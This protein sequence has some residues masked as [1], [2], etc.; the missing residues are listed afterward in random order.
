MKYFGKFD[1]KTAELSKEEI[2]KLLYS[3]GLLIEMVVADEKEIKGKTLFFDITGSDVEPIKDLS[4][5]FC[6]FIID[7]YETPILE[8][9]LPFFK[10]FND[11]IYGLDYKEQKTIGLKY[12]KEIYDTIYIDLI[13]FFKEKK[14][15]NGILETQN[16][17]KLEMLYAQYESLKINLFREGEFIYYL[18]GDKNAYSTFDYSENKIYTEVIEFEAWKQ[19]IVELNNRFEFEDGYYFSDIQQDESNFKKYDYI[20]KTIES[21]HFTNKK[22]L[23]F[24]N[25][26]P[27]KMDSLYEFLNTKNVIRHN[28]VGFKEYC[29]NEYGID[30]KTIHNLEKRNENLAHLK[31]IKK[32]QEDWDNL[33][34]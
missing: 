18:I 22:I 31:R 26:I 34:K 14:N 30:L 27:S 8:I 13:A 1:P 17:S 15:N 4:D 23:N 32:F 11:E 25:N 24:K 28:I 9:K 20:F 29:I 12:F 10:K 19:V 7:L 5:G 2:N 6:E 3:E 16:K 33:F 21:Y